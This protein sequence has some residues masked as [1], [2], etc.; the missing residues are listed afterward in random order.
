MQSIVKQPSKIKYE[1]IL[2]DNGS[3]DDSVSVI[4]E[5][6]PNVRLIENPEN[7]GFAHANNQGMK[8]AKGK[9]FLLLN[10]DT[11][12]LDRALDKMFVFAERHPEAGVFG[13]KLLKFDKTIQPSCFL[14]PSFFN[15]L[16]S[17]FFLNSMFQKNKI[18]GRERMGWFGGERII[19]IEAHSGACLLVRKEAVDQVGMMDDRFFVYGEDADWCWRFRKSGWKI[20]YNPAPEIIH[21]KEHTAS[22]AGPKMQHQLYSGML[23]FI[24]KHK[25]FP[26][27]I[28]SCMGSAVWFF[29]R[30]VIHLLRALILSEGRKESRVMAGVFFDGFFRSFR[31][32]QALRYRQETDV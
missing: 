6:F 30:G 9:Y 8:V 1:I 12:I 3:T 27:Y 31:G 13:S 32:W 20:L 2:I 29:E 15:I 24:K 22:A 5:K 28:L 10:S 21:L 19:E 4:R 17:L 25:P 11:L 18:C 26:V 23:Q 14:C 16:L 7:K